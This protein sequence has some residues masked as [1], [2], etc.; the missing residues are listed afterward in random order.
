MRVI[1]VDPGDKHVGVA[2]ISDGAYEWAVE[3]EPAELLEKL[4]YSRSP[5]VVV[6][7][8]FVLDPGRAKQQAGAM[9]TPELI[10]AIKVLGEIHGFLVVEQQPSVR[11]VCERSPWWKRLCKEKGVDQIKSKHARDALLHALYFTF[12]GKQVDAIERRT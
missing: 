12:F 4:I 7:E 8:A 9:R 3:M 2:S 11:G 6:V 10:G 1:G 5:D